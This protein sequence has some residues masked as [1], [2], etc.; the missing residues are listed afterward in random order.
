MVRSG[1]QFGRPTVR[2]TRVKV[3][4]VVDLAGAGEPAAAVAR[5]FELDELT[6]VR[7]ISWH[8]GYEAGCGADG[9]FDY[10]REDVET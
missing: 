4:V 9:A 2:G 5:E 10:L 8:R 7:A 6:V 3:E 1:I